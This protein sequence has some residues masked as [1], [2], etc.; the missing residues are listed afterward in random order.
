[1]RILRENAPPTSFD[2]VA[3]SRKRSQDVAPGDT[4]CVSEGLEPRPRHY[5]CRGLG[6][7]GAL[8]V[9]RTAHAPLGG[10]GAPCTPGL[11][12]TVTGRSLNFL[13]S[14]NP[15]QIGRSATNAAYAFSSRAERPLPDLGHSPVLPKQLSR[16]DLRFARVRRRTMPDFSRAGDHM[17][18]L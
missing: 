4:A 13:P 16:A 14:T 11:D 10:Q 17:R 5:E 8:P 2:A 1:M 6:T 18:A 15:V 12:C 3:L 7:S 9:R